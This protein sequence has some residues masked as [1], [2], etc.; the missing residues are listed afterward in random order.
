[1][2]KRVKDYKITALVCR[3]GDGDP[4][5]A[6]HLPGGGV[7]HEPD[8]PGARQSRAA[9]VHLLVQKPTG[10]TS[11]NQIMNKANNENRKQEEHWSVQAISVFYFHQVCNR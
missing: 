1:M 5:R 4:G 9:P 8:L 11:S 10:D 7:H 2:E 6:D 3:A